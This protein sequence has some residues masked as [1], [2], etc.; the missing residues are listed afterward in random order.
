MVDNM[1]HI[2]KFKNL[3]YLTDQIKNNAIY[4]NSPLNFNDPL[5]SYFITMF[6]SDETT[7]AKLFTEYLDIGKSIAVFCGTTFDNLNNVLMWTHYADFH[8]GVA[9]KYKIPASVNGTIRPVNY[10]KHEH[11]DFMAAIGGGNPYNIPNRTADEKED[12]ILKS[13]FLK[14][15]EWGYEN[16]LRYVKRLNKMESRIEYGWSIEEIYLGCRF[17]NNDDEKLEEIM[18]IV[19]LCLERKIRIYTMT[20][21]LDSKAKRFML[22]YEP[23]IE[24]ENCMMEENYCRIKRS[25]LQEMKKRTLKSIKGRI[26]EEIARDIAKEEIDRKWQEEL[27]RLNRSLR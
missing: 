19:D 15:S 4:L 22:A 16:E 2:L 8:R 17:L 20:Y 24:N 7:E 25:I 26:V 11:A 1:S 21:H 3:G 9:L 14:N 27:L 23:W 18:R 13:V 5:D 12:A 6:G 10:D